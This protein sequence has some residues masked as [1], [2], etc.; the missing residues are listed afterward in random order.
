LSKAIIMQSSHERFMALA[1]EEAKKAAEMGNI[2]V[3]A[4]IVRNGHVLSRGHNV[5]QSTFD[6]SAHAEAVA[7]RNMTMG[8]RQLNPTSQAASGPFAEAILYAT[9][10]PCPMCC[11]LACIAGISSLVIGARHADLGIPFGDYQVE[12]LIKMTKRNIDLVTG[13]LAT[14]CAALCRSG[15]FVPGPR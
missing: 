8:L 7:V 4:V 13:V 10:E 2:A 1:L 9:L 3:G 14:E 6:I 5:V 15:R 11:W 12:K